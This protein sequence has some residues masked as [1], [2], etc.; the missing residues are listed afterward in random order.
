MLVVEGG[1]STELGVAWLPCAE[2]SEDCWEV[3]LGR[4]PLLVSETAAAE[5]EQLRQMV[6]SGQFLSHRG[7]DHVKYARLG[8]FTVYLLTLS[9]CNAMHQRVFGR[10][11][12][13]VY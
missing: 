7:S 10:G 2:G 6:A 1:G 4:T 5:L 9:E 12:F 11:V 8:P 13:A 3:L